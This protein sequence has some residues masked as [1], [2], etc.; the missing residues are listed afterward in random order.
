MSRLAKNFSEIKE[1]WL[2]RQTGLTRQER[3]HNLW[4]DEMIDHWHPTIQGKFR[5]FKYLVELDPD[6]FFIFHMTI[7]PVE[8][9]YFYP[10]KP[11]GQCAVWCFDRGFPDPFDNNIINI[12]PM[13]N[14]YLFVAT[15]CG[16]DA[17][18]M[19]LQFK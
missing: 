9:K 8:P 1:W 18:E 4:M 7:E 10:H 15:N 11:S 5:K 3:D 13:G 6:K 2:T 17:I 14:E 16:E 19:T 12:T